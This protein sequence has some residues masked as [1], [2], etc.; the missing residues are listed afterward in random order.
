MKRQVIIK[1][2][3]FNMFITAVCV[4][5]LIIRNIVSSPLFYV[6]STSGKADRGITQV[7]Q[8]SLFTN[9][10]TKTLHM[11]RSHPVLRSVSANNLCQYLLDECTTWPF[12]ILILLFKILF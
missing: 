8:P 4:L 9:M 12:Q 11:L 2:C 10:P 7:S 3:K 1:M 6:E 5:F